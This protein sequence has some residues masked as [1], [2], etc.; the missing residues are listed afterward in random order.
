MYKFTLN[1]YQF[2]LNVYK[3]ILNVRK[4][5][6]IVYEFVLHVYKFATQ[7]Y[8]R[9]IQPNSEP[10]IVES[11]AELALIKQTRCPPTPK[12][13]ISEGYVTKFAPHKAVK[14]IA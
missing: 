9:Q 6:L 11:E 3:F 4:F 7:V 14:L 12:P 13:R 10:L 5:V 8:T 2:V 1:V